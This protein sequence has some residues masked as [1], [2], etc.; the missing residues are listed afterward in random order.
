V[1]DVSRGL[2]L[3]LHYEINLIT[4]VSKF[5]M[6]RSAI[7]SYSYRNSRVTLVSTT[8]EVRAYASLLLPSIGNYKF[9]GFKWYRIIEISYQSL[10][11]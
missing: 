11:I 7:D 9:T 10:S 2:I 1:S 4:T 8:S 5:I 6:I 3:T